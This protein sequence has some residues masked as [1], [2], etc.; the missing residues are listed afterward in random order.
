[1][2]NDRPPRVGPLPPAPHP[3]PLPAPRRTV[4][5]PVLRVPVGLE[6]EM[7]HTVLAA[8]LAD[9]RT[10]TAHG[11]TPA[12]IARTVADYLP[13][14]DVSPERTLTYTDLHT[15]LLQA[16]ST[17]MVG[18]LDDPTLTGDHHEL[19]TALSRVLLVR[20]ADVPVALPDGRQSTLGALYMLHALQALPVDYPVAAFSLLLREV[21]AG[22]ALPERKRL[23][24]DFA[25]LRTV[26]APEV[27]RLIL[28]FEAEAASDSL[29]LATQIAA[30]DETAHAGELR[31]ALKL[32]RAAATA[33]E[34]PAGLAAIRSAT[35]TIGRYADS[36]A[37]PV[38]MTL[39]GKSPEAEWWYWGQ[40]AQLRRAIDDALGKIEQRSTDL[41]T[42]STVVAEQPHVE[43]VDSVAAPQLSAAAAWERLPQCLHPVVLPTVGQSSM[44]L[45]SLSGG[46]FV[47]GSHF[48]SDFA[49]PTWC[50]LDPFLIGVAPVTESQYHAVTENR[51]NNKSDLQMP[52][53][54]ITA[55]QADTFCR[56]AGLRVPT[57]A[58]VEFA[59]RGPPVDV[60]RLAA[61]LQVKTIA[62]LR[63]AMKD[64]NIQLENAVT[65]LRLGGDIVANLQS[66]VFA[67]WFASDQPIWA[68]RVYATVSGSPES[69]MWVKQSGLARVDRADACRNAY[70][71][72]DAVGNVW[73][74][75]AD[76]Y[77]KDAYSE[78]GQV[79]PISRKGEKRV[80]RGWSWCDNDE[81]R[82]AHRYNGGGASGYF[83]FRVGGRAPGL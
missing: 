50:Q 10:V 41:V 7:P 68:W 34:F 59:H 67:A 60:R 53:T 83:G 6:S 80:V 13:Y 58:E 64:H 9:L 79:N 42:T 4:T 38:L 74:W 55:R 54:G 47:R 30:Q 33:A 73:E 57:E 39:R 56:R 21:L 17:L 71:L 43:V 24:E 63:A 77:N 35:E 22:I 1:M 18:I 14:P 15:E 45:L 62:D 61:E 76:L 25:A 75:C 81:P 20:G 52:V 69:S 23:V 48:Y 49:P 28:A 8:C 72:I 66:D 29:P 44:T 19:M 40:A 2:S 3:A 26:V 70:G 78:L 12:L 27:R 36:T 5:S 11:G 65:A 82:V 51:G 16:V 37:R 31:T 32:A 46:N